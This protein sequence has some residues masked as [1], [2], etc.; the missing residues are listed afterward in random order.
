[1]SAQHKEKYYLLVCSAFC[2]ALLAARMV[3]THTFEYRFMAV[4]LFLAWL[5]WIFSIWS[6]NLARRNMRWLM[7]ITAFLWLIF[8]PNA[9]YMITDIFHLSE[10]PSMPMWYDL[11]MLLSFAWSG[12]LLGFY[13]LKK[14]F[15]LFK[16]QRLVAHPVS[17]FA[18]FFICG[19]GIYLGRYERWNS[20]EIIT[21]PKTLIT[22]MYY[23]LS[24]PAQVM[25]MIS[26]SFLFAVFF[27]MVY[28][29]VFRRLQGETVS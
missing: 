12:L 26:L 7:V 8:F 16:N 18:I 20:W 1:M 6:L 9:P 11:I 29:A 24:D 25:H 15:R 4:N 10:F 19:T 17:I 2:I 3:Y 22:D 23:L 14:I 28:I 21:R 13:S 27:T 5:P